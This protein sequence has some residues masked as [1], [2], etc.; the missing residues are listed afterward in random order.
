NR[1]GQSSYGGSYQNAEDDPLWQWMNGAFNR[2]GDSAGN[3]R[4]RYYRYTPPR[5]PEESKGEG[6]SGIVSSGVMFFLG[7]FLFKYLFWFFPIG[8]II[9]LFLLVK[10][11]SGFFRSLGRLLE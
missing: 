10:G 2:N 8:P 11:V 3:T 6:L 1:Y 7:L 5:Q 9:C 4:Y